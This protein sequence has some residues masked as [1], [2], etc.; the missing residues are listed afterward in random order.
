MEGSA[1]GPKKRW[2]ILG[3]KAKGPGD[4]TPTW[5]QETSEVM[6]WID[7]VLQRIQPSLLH[8]CYTHG[9]LTRVQCELALKILT[10][11][12]L[13]FYTVQFL[14]RSSLCNSMLQMLNWHCGEEKPILCQKSEEVFHSWERRTGHQMGNEVIENSLKNSTD[15]TLT[16]EPWSGMR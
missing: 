7:R 16:T 10:C 11:Q 8:F 5:D 1:P 6:S 15:W 13:L 14:P 2:D 3:R 4:H 12:A 9:S